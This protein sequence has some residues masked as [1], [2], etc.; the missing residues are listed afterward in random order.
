MTWF[1]DGSDYSA[2][3]PTYPAEIASALAAAA[4]RTDSAVDVGCGTGQL[5]VLLAQHFSRVLGIDPSDDQIRNA[6][7]A[8]GIEYRV[9]PAERLDVSDG[10]ASLI[11]VAQA[12]HWFDLPA[13]YAEARR[14]AAD[15]ALLALITYGVVHLDDD[16]AERFDVFYRDE[17]G[18]Y[19][20]PERRHVDN[21][22]ADLDF[23]FDRVEI[24][25]MAIERSWT[26]AE[27][28]GYLGTWSAAR[29]AHE[30]GAGGLLDAL[31]EDLAPVWGD[32]RRTV[33]WPVTVLAG[34]VA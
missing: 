27:F 29:R 32:G 20:P 16:L 13:F 2:Y 6:T 25:P 10:S 3:R 5:T 8:A 28:V 19:W 12:A 4:P 1:T 7:Q 9:C 23:P 18:P 24:P 31:A 30:A 34:R 26:L 15:D 11:T 14:I 22:Y 33:R 21:G 17:I